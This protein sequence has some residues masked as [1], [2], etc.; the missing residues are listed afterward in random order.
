MSKSLSSLIAKIAR[1][2]NDYEYRK[3]IRDKKKSLIIEN[4]IKEWK[5]KSHIEF[6]K[7]IFII[8]DDV[9]LIKK[10]WYLVR[11][12]KILKSKEE[13]NSLISKNAITR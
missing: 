7:H 13:A 4:A 11:L 5:I 1:L 9:V 10:K 2:Q 6:L 3:E 12:K 8:E